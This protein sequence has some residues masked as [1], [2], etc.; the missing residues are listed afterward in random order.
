MDT[1]MNTDVTKEI[2]KMEL[3]VQIARLYYEY[4]LS[5]NEIAK[6]VN[7][8]RPYISKLLNE[9]KREGIVKIEIHDPLCTENRWERKLR[10]YF[11]LKKAVVVP[12]A[13]GENP[14]QQ[15]GI[16]AAR[17]LDSILK[18][19]DVIG[20][21][22]GRTIYECAKAL[23]RRE[24]L[25]NTVAFQ[26]CGGV[27]NLKKNVYASEITKAFVD[28]LKSSGYLLPFPAIVDS[29]QLR[30]EIDKENTLQE[31]L[32]YADKINVAIMTTGPI[33]NQCALAKAGYLKPDEIELLRKKGA[34]GD[35]CTHVIDAEGRICDEDLDSRTVAVSYE[36][37]K[38]I[39]TRIGVGIGE[40]KVESLLGMLNGKSINVFV[41]DE[42][43]A[44]LMKERR[45]EIFE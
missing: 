19:G 45:P 37:I 14:L 42:S 16:A 7:L 11:G 6:K 38:R 10:E 35:V 21:S 36:N 41:T 44:E 13:D 43:T 24:D 20:F 5:Q 25:K 39:E 8:S 17:Y 29:R 40:T 12:K 31:V 23:K 3:L 15:V 9:A 2:Q 22:W 27:S 33:D 26:M 1:G 30:E 18:S 32:G 28:M 4:N 34:V